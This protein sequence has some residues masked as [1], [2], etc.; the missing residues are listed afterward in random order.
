VVTELIEDA[1]MSEIERQLNEASSAAKKDDYDKALA[2]CNAVLQA[3]P[4]FPEAL[5]T[6]SEIYTRMGD[7][8][9]AIADLTEVIKTA[10]EPSDFFFRG[11]R[12]LDNGDTD[13]AIGDFSKALELGEDQNFHYHDQSAR[14]FRALACVRAKRYDEAL[15]DCLHVKDDFLIYTRSTGKITKADV[16]KQARAGKAKKK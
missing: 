7:L 13:C 9:R 4:L 6:R 2:I 10:G 1:V 12:Y 16:V 5:R 3:H 11:W 14:F 8:E 15:A